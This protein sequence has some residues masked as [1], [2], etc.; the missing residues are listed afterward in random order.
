MERL[1]ERIEGKR[2]GSR[3]IVLPTRLVVHR[4]CGGRLGESARRL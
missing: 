1:L 4:T 2:T 3:E